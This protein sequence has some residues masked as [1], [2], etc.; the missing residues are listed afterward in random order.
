MWT[1]NLSKQWTKRPGLNII[2]TWSILSQLRCPQGAWT[3]HIWSKC[4]LAKPSSHWEK[5]MRQPVMKLNLLKGWRIVGLGMGESGGI[6]P[7]QCVCVWVCVS[8]ALTSCTHTGGLCCQ[9]LN[10]GLLN[11]LDR[12]QGGRIYCTTGKVELFEVALK[13]FI[14]NRN[15]FLE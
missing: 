12:K 10:A 14:I 6:H 13:Y 9:N 1:Q 15:V 4:S 3:S 7:S 11:D 5:E 8:M 2:T